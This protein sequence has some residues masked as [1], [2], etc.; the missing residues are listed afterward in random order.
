MLMSLT[1][2]CPQLDVAYTKGVG[3]VSFGLIACTEVLAHLIRHQACLVA[4]PKDAPSPVDGPRCTPQQNVLCWEHS[5]VPVSRE[6]C[7]GD[8]KLK[9]ETFLLR[10]VL[11]LRR[12]WEQGKLGT[13]RSVRLSGRYGPQ[14]EES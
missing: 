4:S 8:A 2:S 7:S 9:Q 1:H 14:A 5:P 6:H 12:G 11:T 13:Q 10:L 3:E